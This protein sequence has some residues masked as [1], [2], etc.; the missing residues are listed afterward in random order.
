MPTYAGSVPCVC[1]A[2]LIRSIVRNI[3]RNIVG[4]PFDMPIPMRDSGVADALPVEQALSDAG[5]R[6]SCL[7]QWPKG[8]TPGGCG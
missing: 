7:R 3:V 2:A 8:E 1:L 5:R 4:V 6:V